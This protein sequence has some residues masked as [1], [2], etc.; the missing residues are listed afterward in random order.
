MEIMDIHTHLSN[1]NY[2]VIAYELYH[3][4]GGNLDISTLVLILWQQIYFIL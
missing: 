2:V 1:L 3:I 4:F